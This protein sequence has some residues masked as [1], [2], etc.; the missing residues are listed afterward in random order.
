LRRQR[1]GNL[2]NGQR[3]GPLYYD[4]A[5]V[6]L[7]RGWGGT[8]G[9]DR[10]GQ[11]ECDSEG[12]AS[13]D[14]EGDSLDRDISTSWDKGIGAALDASPSSLENG[15][16]LRAPSSAWWLPIV[17]SAPAHSVG[18][19]RLLRSVLAVALSRDAARPIRL[20]TTCRLRAQDPSGCKGGRGISGVDRS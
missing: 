16:P 18:Q 3:I 7:A 12:A 9:A 8:A 19:L 10:S 17:R 5:S 14:L 20:R 15:K 4:R 13:R 6:L 11:E 1:G 2:D